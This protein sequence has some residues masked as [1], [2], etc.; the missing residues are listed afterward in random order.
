MPNLLL[1]VFADPVPACP[2]GEAD[3]NPGTERCLRTVDLDSLQVLAHLPHDLLDGLHGIRQEA[4][5]VGRV[6]RRGRG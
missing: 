4:G 1:L 2:A 5:L 6:Y 3:L